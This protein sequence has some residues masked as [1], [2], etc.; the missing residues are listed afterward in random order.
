MERAG[1]RETGPLWR[2]W[3]WENPVPDIFLEWVILQL[4]LPAV[5]FN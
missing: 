2:G 1:V 4:A 3:E 5:P